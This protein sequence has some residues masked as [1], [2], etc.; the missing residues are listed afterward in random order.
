MIDISRD[1]ILFSIA[2]GWLADLVMMAWLM[3][4]REM[5]RGDAR[6]LRESMQDV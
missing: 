3:K 1:D 5:G 2:N 4:G 6:R